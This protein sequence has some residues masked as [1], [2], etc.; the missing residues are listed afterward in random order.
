M[1]HSS[2]IKDKRKWAK[3]E[4]KYSPGCGMSDKCGQNQQADRVCVCVCVGVKQNKESVGLRVATTMAT[5]RRGL[6]CGGHPVVVFI[7][8]RTLA[9][10]RTF[11]TGWHRGKH[12]GGGKGRDEKD[13]DRRSLADY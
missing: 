12:K 7:L 1:K 6:S 3:L 4:R 5:T 10:G 8:V 11:A 13:G 9:D 2:G